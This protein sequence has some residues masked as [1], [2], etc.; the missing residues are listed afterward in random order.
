VHELWQHQRML[1]VSTRCPQ[2]SICGFT[3]KVKLMRH[4]VKLT[5]DLRKAQN[6]ESTPHKVETLMGCVVL[7]SFVSG[8]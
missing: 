2:R 1:L 4:K 5:T 7:E 3:H 6:R 8:T